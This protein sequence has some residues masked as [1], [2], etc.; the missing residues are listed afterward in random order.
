MRAE[1][2]SRAVRVSG[3]AVKGNAAGVYSCGSSRT[4][5]ALRNNA[6]ALEAQGRAAIPFVSGTD[7]NRR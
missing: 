6:T 4:V 2:S 3:E 5:V 1:L 7:A